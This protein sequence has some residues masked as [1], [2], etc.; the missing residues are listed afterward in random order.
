MTGNITTRPW[1]TISGYPLAANEMTTGSIKRFP[2]NSQTSSLEPLWIDVTWPQNG[3]LNWLAVRR[4]RST[5]FFFFWLH[6]FY[7]PSW[8]NNA[9]ERVQQLPKLLP[10]MISPPAQQHI[11]SSASSELHFKLLRL[12][13]K[14][15]ESISPLNSPLDVFHL[16]NVLRWERKVQYETGN[17]A[18]FIYPQTSRNSCIAHLEVAVFCP[19]NNNFTAF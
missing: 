14:I 8:W 11:C 16:S 1:N 10:K 19:R 9:Q 13:A 2:W 3:I 15:T 18:A 4:W 7:P 17:C 6:L 5:C 12:C